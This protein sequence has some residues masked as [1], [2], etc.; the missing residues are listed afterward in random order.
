MLTA[1]DLAAYIAG[2]HIQAELLPMHEDTP[3]V[4]DAARAL[5]VASEQI[6]KSVVFLVDGRPHLV[7]ANGLRR[8]SQGKLAARFGLG[9]KRV[10]LAPPDVVLD[11][12]GYP[13]G[14]MPPFGHLTPLPTL[15]DR[16]VLAQDEVF[17]GG[18][19]IDYLLRIT[20]EELLRATRA[21]VA[22]VTEEDDTT[23]S[24]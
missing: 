9:K 23:R 18:G 19:A 24:A 5:G 7:I 10:R 15:L 4:A 22:E 14:T 8:I 11:V 13:V 2:H 3:T 16:H 21:E 6:V 20:P 17:A 12:T 1:A